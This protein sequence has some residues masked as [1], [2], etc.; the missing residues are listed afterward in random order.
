[1]ETQLSQPRSPA[2]P[3]KHRL[4]TT[5]FRRMAEVGIL[6]D[7]VADTTLDYDQTTKIPLYARSGI[8]EIWLVNLRDAVIEV[9]RE[10]GAQGYARVTRVERDQRIAPPAFA[11][12]VLTVEELFR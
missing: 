1:M 2:A 11:D 6:R 3:A 5:E 4:T 12:R 7:E 8:A 9:F 10:S